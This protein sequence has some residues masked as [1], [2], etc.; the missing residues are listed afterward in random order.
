MGER[1]SEMR[2]EKQRRQIEPPSCVWR[3]SD[4]GWPWEHD[5]GGM[6]RS[7]SPCREW[8]WIISGNEME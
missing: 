1:G 5:F 3:Q 7:S 4:D 6:D 8:A 2:L